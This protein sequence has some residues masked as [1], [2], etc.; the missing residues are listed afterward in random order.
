[1]A[2]RFPVR[3]VTGGRGK[4][5]KKYEGLECYLPVVL[6]RR[7]RARG[8]GS[9]ERGSRGGSGLAQRRSGDDGVGD[10]GRGGSVEVWEGDDEARSGNAG[11]KRPV[12]GEHKHASGNGGF[13]A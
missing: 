1:M 13:Q 9:A 10:L 4:V 8:G 7:E 11:R 12:R 2:R 5:G 6:A 3:R